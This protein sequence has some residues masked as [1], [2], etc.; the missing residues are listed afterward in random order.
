MTSANRAV[1]ALLAE[2]MKLRFPRLPPVPPARP[3]QRP[4]RASRL[5][6]E[7]P[8]AS[9]IPPLAGF[10]QPPQSETVVYYAEQPAAFAHRSLSYFA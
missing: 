6:R 10:Y 8:A 3:P 2:T 9:H 5:R 4:P 7:F 1:Y